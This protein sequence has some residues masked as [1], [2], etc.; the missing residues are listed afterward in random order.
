MIL[1]ELQLLR[2][3]VKFW[4]ILGGPA[5]CSQVKKRYVSRQKKWA[6]KD[7]F[8]SKETWS[9]VGGIDLHRFATESWQ[10]PPSDDQSSWSSPASGRK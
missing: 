6:K 3:E 2:S 5:C 7:H 8:M 9:T 10:T 4:H 1:E